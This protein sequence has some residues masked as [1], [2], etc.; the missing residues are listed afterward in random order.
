MRSTDPTRF[1]ATGEQVSTGTPFWP[2]PPE[3][4]PGSLPKSTDVLVIGGGITGV[5]LLHHLGKRGID[6]V[7]VERH[8][9]AAGASGRNAGFLL[10]GVADSYAEA[11]R[12]YGRARA[13]EIWN[14]TVENHIEEIEA[15]AGQPIGHR[16]SGSMILA[17]SDQEVQQLAES[18]Q[19]LSEDGFECSWDG[20]RLANPGDGEVTPS[21]LVGAFARLAS[22]G[23]VREGVEVTAIES[24]KTGVLVHAAGAE[25]RA[26]KVILATNAYTSQLLPQVAIQPRRA[27][28]LA[29]EPEAARLCD[30]PTYSH[31]G[32]R[33]WRQLPSG[34]VL[35]GGWRDTAYDEE[36][37]YDERPTAGIQAHLE[38]HLRQ[39]GAGGKV[40]HRWA[41]TMGF[42]ESGLPLVGPVDGMPNVYL[43]AGYNGHGMGFAFMSAKQLVSSV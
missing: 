4:Y 33:Y 13:R 10:A 11:V 3:R 18:A 14:M 29:S 36:V 41:G 15:V 30:Q 35:V 7:L 16:R 12:I 26:G 25:C 23:S 6:A 40:T 8:H 2:L 20:T 27:Q 37:G 31:F 34:E 24:S 38:A 9:L 43:C 42:T 19:L 1:P 21:L 5:T 32:Y 28:M 22:P 17:S 39:M